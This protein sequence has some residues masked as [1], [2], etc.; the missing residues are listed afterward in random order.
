MN[1]RGVISRIVLITAVLVFFASGFAP[2]RES[3][4]AET[5]PIGITIL[6]DNYVFREGTKAGWGFSCLVEHPEKRVLFDTGNQCTTLFHN[7]NELGV[8]PTEVDLVVVSHAHR[9]HAG[10]LC[11]FLEQ[12]KRATVY[13]PASCPQHL[14]N[15][16]NYAGG[17]TV[18]VRE[19][20]EICEGVFLTG[21]MGSGTKEQ[22]LILVTP[23][24]LVIITG[25]AHPGIVNILEKA[26]EILPNRIYLVLGGFHLIGKSEEEIDKI[27]ADFR[28]LK[29]MK[30]GPTACTGH[31]NIRSFR[32]AYGDGFVQMGVGRTLEI[33]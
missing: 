9:T 8:S 22:S 5:N 32:E 20:R 14:A 26:K 23:Q 18:R 10:G 4:A 21:E 11:R 7:M 29:V 33:Q 16:V 13:M 2:I 27:M 19:P 30:V 6:Y 24:G 15:R 28:R 17:S 25:C 12:N 31:K 1:T 3:L